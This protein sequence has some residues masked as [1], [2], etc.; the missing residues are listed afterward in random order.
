MVEG[1]SNAGDLVDIRDKRVFLGMTYDW[2]DDRRCGLESSFDKRSGVRDEL[3]AEARSGPQ[4]QTDAHSHAKDTSSSAY[5]IK[6]QQKSSSG[7]EKSRQPVVSNVER[8]CL[9][10]QMNAI[11]SRPCPG[12]VAPSEGK[13]GTVPLAGDSVEEVDAKP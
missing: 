3:Q 10:A 6:K 7:L 11:D 4:K 5:V 12:C 8:R 2:S 1:N 9:H 13:D